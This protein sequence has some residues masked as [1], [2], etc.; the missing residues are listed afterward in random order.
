MYM[1]TV[2]QIVQHL[3]PGGIEVMALELKKTLPK[4]TQVILVSLI[5]RLA[6]LLREVGATSIHTHHIGPLIYGGLAARL[7]GIKSHVHTEHDAWHLD[8]TKRRWQQRLLLALTKP[9]L[10]ADSE[11]VAQ[12]I[13]K[14]LSQK[15]VEVIRNG[16]DLE[17][18]IPANQQRARKLM[19]IHSD[20]FWIG[21][22]GRL[23]TVKGHR[24]LIDAMKYLPESTHLALAGSGS[25]FK[26]LRKQVADLGIQNR[27]HFMGH[28]DNMPLFYQALDLFCLP[29][30]REGMPLAPLEAQAC[31]VPVVV[32]DTGGTRETL[33]KESGRLVRPGDSKQLAEA[34]T[35]AQHQKIAVSPRVFV[36]QTANLL[37]MAQA[38]EKHYQLSSQ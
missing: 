2:V 20:V 3:C 14:Y 31:G 32:S 19:K 34:I 37:H 1:K 35:K 15:N 10:I 11:Q 17:R 30:F 24:T 13:K 36:E 5:T 16:V 9:T 6:N 33:C 26:A 23:E 4:D 29:S 38:Y 18:F 28:L 25:Q 27:V 8:K 21:S 12:G 22:S 7:A